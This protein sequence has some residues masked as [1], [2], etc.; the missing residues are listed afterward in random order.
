M[1]VSAEK[2]KMYYKDALVLETQMLANYLVDV[3]VMCDDKIEIFSH[4]PTRNSPDESRGCF[5]Y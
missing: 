4:K 3:I 1:R 2:N 5:V